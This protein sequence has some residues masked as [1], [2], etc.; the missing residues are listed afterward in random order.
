ASDFGEA[1]NTV[2]ADSVASYARVQGTDGWYYGSATV[3][4]PYNPASFVPLGWGS[5]Y[6]YIQAETMHPYADATSDIWVVRRW[7]S[8]AAGT[9]TLSG[10]INGPGAG[11]A[12]VVAHILINGTEVYHQAISAGATVNYAVSNITINHGDNID[13]AIEAA[14]H[15]ID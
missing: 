4:G 6:P 8:S 14:G 13:F 2:V 11:S 10:T 9:A 3:G 12:G 1:S 7:R 5:G 15:S